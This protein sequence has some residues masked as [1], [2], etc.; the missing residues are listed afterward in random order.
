MAQPQPHLAHDQEP[1]SDDRR[2]GVTF[3]KRVRRVLPGPKA[4]IDAFRRVLLPLLVALIPLWWVCDATY[5]A[6]LVTIGR[7]QGIFQ[8]IAWAVRNGDVDYA[9]VRDVNGPLIHLVHYV[10]MGWGGHEEHR[11]HVLH[12]TITGIT[13]AIAGACLA[14]FV[15]GKRPTWLERAAWAAAGWVILSGQYQLYLYWNQAQRETFCD[16]FLV[17]AIGLQIARP[18]ESKR[19]ESLRIGLIGA[20]SVIAWFGKPSF[21]LFT[22]A[23]MAVLF[24]DR[25][26]TTTRKERLFRFAIGG[27][28]GAAIPLLYLFAHGDALAFLRITM[29][30]VPAMYRFIWVKSPHEILGSD[31]PLM[32][33]AAGM[34]AAALVAA[35]VAMRE[36]PRRALVLALAPPIAVVHVLVQ[37]KGFGYH[38]HPLT[39]ATALAWLAVIALLWQ[40]HRF[41]P[42]TKPLGRWLAF[43]AATTLAFYT[44]KEMNGSPNL[45]HVW[46]LAGAATPYKRGLPEYFDQFKSYDFF[47]WDMRLTAEYLDKK[48]KPEERVQVYGMDPYLLYLARRKSATPYIYAYDLNVDTALDGGWWATPTDREAE[49]IKQM[50]FDHEMDMLARLKKSPPPAF[51]FISGAPLISYRDALEDFAHCCGTTNNW[52]HDEYRHAKTFGEIQVWLRKDLEP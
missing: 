36:L 23:Q 2:S 17:P 16:W 43:A 18:A 49:R 48:T 52:V 4:R 15:R 32:T 20:L 5:R 42:R 29:R 46:L 44:A 35:L 14:G 30:D 8:Y 27:A 28:I 50:R 25:D 41:A 26:L 39:A 24:W 33:T 12:L 34:A 3:V 6:S 10:L 37:A 19:N 22:L 9:D 45:R 7:D 11:F 31:G 38:F 47:P 40:K 13:F 1:A 21:A 51:V